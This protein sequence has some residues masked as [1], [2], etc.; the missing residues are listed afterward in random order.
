MSDSLLTF[1]TVVE[2]VV[3]V[4][5]LASGLLIVAAKLRSISKTLSEVTWGGRAVE[6]QLL[7]V[8]SN[9]RQVNAALEDIAGTLPHASQRLEQLGRQEVGQ[10]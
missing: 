7:A 9:I 1:L 6:R 3:L 8:R 10:P 5:V 4:A 2:V